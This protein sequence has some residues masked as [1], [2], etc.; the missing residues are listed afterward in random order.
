[1]IRA[2]GSILGLRTPSHN[3]T[4]TTSSNNNTTNLSGS[5]IQAEV[6]KKA[7]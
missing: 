2:G 5:E 7:A 3:P 6:L 4:T 1:M